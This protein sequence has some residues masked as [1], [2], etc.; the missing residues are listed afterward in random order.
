MYLI[1]WIRVD[2]VWPIFPL[3]WFSKCFCLLFFLSALHFPIFLAN[4]DQRAI[5]FDLCYTCSKDSIKKILFQTFI[6]W[7]SRTKLFDLYCPFKTLISFIKSLQ[8]FF[9]F[10]YFYEVRIRDN[11]VWPV[12]SFTKELIWF[13]L[14]QLF[15]LLEKL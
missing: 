2:T 12:L 7:K 8:I 9:Y 11:T 3:I 15:F 1:N 10:K 14:V 4:F 13:D 5:R 6:K